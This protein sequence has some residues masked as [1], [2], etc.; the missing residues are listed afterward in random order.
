MKYL[1]ALAAAAALTAVASAT[2]AQSANP[3][4]IRYSE[5]PVRVD[6]KLDDPAWTDATALP[7]ARTDGAAVQGG[8][9]ARL[10]WD[11]ARLYLALDIPDE[12]IVADRSDRDTPIWEKDDVVELFVWPREDQ[13]YYYEIAVNPRNTVFDSFFVANADHTGADVSVRDWNPDIQSLTRLQP[14]VYRPNKVGPPSVGGSWTVEMGIPMSAFSNLAAG[15]PTAG[16]VWRIQIVRF[17][18]PDP[19]PGQLDATSLSPYAPITEPFRLDS[20]AG[21]RFQGGPAAVIPPLVPKSPL[22]ASNTASPSAPAVTAPVEPAPAPEPNPAP[23]AVTPVAPPVSVAPPVDT[24]PAVPTPPAPV[25]PAQTAPAP[26]QPVTL[27]FHNM[28]AGAALDLLF[29]GT[30]LTYALSPDARPVTSSATVSA[31]LKNAPFE[32]ALN[33]LLGQINLGYQKQGTM[34]V[35]TPKAAGGA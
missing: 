11:N 29:Q 8:A 24:T 6:G 23:E 12:V 26:P 19:G 4:D 25:S 10:A 5:K 22:Q 2:F 15:P 7:L 3:Y 18:R 32:T 35:I 1:T 9:V 31:D 34:Y 28:R 13:P 21:I 16:D 14:V 20:F 30:G 27:N 17:N 33:T